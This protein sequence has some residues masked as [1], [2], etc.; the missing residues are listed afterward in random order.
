MYKPDSF[1]YY[2][3]ITIKSKK[4][5]FPLKCTITKMVKVCNECVCAISRRWRSA[6]TTKWA[7]CDELDRLYMRSHAHLDNHK[8][9]YKA[10]S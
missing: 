8:A 10:I 2:N 3:N 1:P 5:R 7:V 4:C 6:A 9:I